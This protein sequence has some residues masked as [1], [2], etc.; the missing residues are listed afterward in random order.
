MDLGKTSLISCFL[1]KKLDPLSSEF[2]KSLSIDKFGGKRIKF[3][4]FAPAGQ[5]KF[6][7]IP[8]SF[9]KDAKAA[10]LVYDITDKVSFVEMKNY[11]YQ[12][13]KKYT[14]KILY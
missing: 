13:I 1:N 12:Q 11:W 10:I 2:N 14:P 4:I 7:A 8:N 5:E 3:N 6:G 9:Y